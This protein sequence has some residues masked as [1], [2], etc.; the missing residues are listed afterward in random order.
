MVHKKY[1]AVPIQRVEGLPSA[2]LQ[3]QAPIRKQLHQIQTRLHTH[4]A[5]YKALNAT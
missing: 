1:I 3:F 5:T 2:S 4:A